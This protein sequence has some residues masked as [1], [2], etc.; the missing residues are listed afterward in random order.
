MVYEIVFAL[1]VFALL[2]LVAGGTFGFGFIQI[3]DIFAAKKTGKAKH[4]DDIGAAQNELFKLG[5]HLKRYIEAYKIKFLRDEMSKRNTSY[6][7]LD[8]IIKEVLTGKSY[9]KH[10]LDQAEE[11]IRGDLDS[12]KEEITGK[13]GK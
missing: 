9:N 8:S 10:V 7:E 3:V 12:V 5:H 13:R 6:K 1:F 11:E 4:S 2:A